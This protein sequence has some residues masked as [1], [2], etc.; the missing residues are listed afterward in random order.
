MS[1]QFIALYLCWSD[2]GTC[3]YLDYCVQ[4]DLEIL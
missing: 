3:S 4:M 2:L 1:N